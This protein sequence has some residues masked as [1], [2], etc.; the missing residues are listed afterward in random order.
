M[1]VRF[2]LL[3]L[4]AIGNGILPFHHVLFQKALWVKAAQE[5]E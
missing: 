3:C 1:N 2:T 4:K 5:T